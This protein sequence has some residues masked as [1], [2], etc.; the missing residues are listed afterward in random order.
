MSPSSPE[1]RLRLAVGAGFRIPDLG[2]LAEGVAAGPE[3]E[4]RTETAYYDTPDLQLA[5]WGLSL[6]QRR[7]EGWTLSLPA[8]E[9]GRRPVELS[10]PHS[11]RNPPAEALSLVRAYVRGA[12]LRPVAQLSTRGRAVS[13]RD[14]E[15]RELVQLV[16]DEVSVLEGRRVAS[17]FRELE[18]E[19]REGGEEVLAALL[20]R[21]QDSGAYPADGPPPHLRALGPAAQAPP[22]PA[23]VELPATPTGADVVRSALSAG[24][25]QLLRNDLGLRVGDDPESVHQARVATRRLRSHLRTF[26]PLLQEEW[27]RELRDELGWL[28]DQLGRVRDAEV[29]LEHLREEAQRLPAEDARPAAALLGRL[30]ETV[31]REKEGLRATI[32][33]ERYVRLLDRLVEAAER[34]AL[35]EE[36]GLP[37]AEVLPARVRKAWRSLR[38]E[39]RQLGAEPEDAELHRC[40]ILAKRVRYAAEVTAPAVG[41]DAERMAKAAAGLQT[42]LGEHQDAVVAQGWLRANAGGGRRAFAAGELFM[43]ETERAAATRREWPVAWKRL[44]RKRLRAWL[45]S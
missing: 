43:G 35:S 36:A 4:L 6:R 10:F 17:R 12:Q 23:P 31:A 11:S 37:A 20:A 28:A 25:A 13:L 44:N 3:R 39:V 38:R 9:D 21:L 30:R 34:P 24:V 42:V 19:L 2:E 29:L 22:E 16:D 33:G 27:A 45:G 40:R 7:G 5:R 15:G 41:P 32:G 14:A 1:G 26:Q 18:V 8:A